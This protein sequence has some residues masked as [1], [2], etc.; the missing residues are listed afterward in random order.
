M[1]T[2]VALAYCLHAM[3]GEL[4][5]G[6]LV[7]KQ[8]L[9]LRL[10]VPA[11]SRHQIVLSRS[12]QP[13]FIFPRRTQQGDAASQRFKDAYGGNAA[14]SVGILST[15]HMQGHF[16]GGIDFRSSQVG[17]IPSILHSRLEQ[18]G[19][20][21]RGIANAVRNHTL[22][23]QSRRWFDQE[24]LQLV[25]ALVISPVANPNQIDFLRP[26]LGMKA[27]HIRCFVKRPCPAHAEAS[28][29][30]A[31]QGLTKSQDSVYQVQVE[32]Q[33]LAGSGVRAMMAVIEQGREAQLALELQDCVDHQEVVPF[34][35][36]DQVTIPELALQKL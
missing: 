15:R 16:T 11:V 1:R 29:V 34:V 10:Q 6:S 2:G 22:P 24:F 18:H 36:E 14:Q 17:Q 28:S 32:A 33:D 30:D 27:T 19:D 20:S 7:A 8:V 9:E 31:A 12:K 5:A 13:L 23:G 26:S 3:F 21:S 4:T 25:R 35:H